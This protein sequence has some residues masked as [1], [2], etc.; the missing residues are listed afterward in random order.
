MLVALAASAAFA[1]GGD[2]TFAEAVD[3][4][5]PRA[6][7]LDLYSSPDADRVLARL[8]AAAST[9]GV[10]LRF[11]HALRLTRG[12]GSNPLGLDRGW[13][14]SGRIVRFRR[15]GKRVVAEVE[16]HRYRAVT[17]RG[18]ER[19]AIA[20]SFANSFVWSAEVID[21]D[22]CRRP[23]TATGSVRRAKRCLRA[24]IRPRVRTV[25][26]ADRRGPSRLDRRGLL[27]LRGL[28]TLRDG[29][30]VTAHV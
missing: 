17:D 2:E 12:L 25:A 3:G 8:P 9:D 23:T 6:G 5:T 1:E 18:A 27:A 22:G 28:G 13:G 15:I 7:F 26:R 19:Q 10:L 16:N 29:F 24:P 11:I 21:E 30:R 4:L 14:A 20:E